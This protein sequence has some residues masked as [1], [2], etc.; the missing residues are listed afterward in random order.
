MSQS[1]SD[2]KHFLSPRSIA[3]VGASSKFDS[4]S[5]KPL[6]FLQEHGYKGYVYPINPKYPELLGYKCYKSVLEIPDEVDLV[7]V[8][9]NYKLVLPMLKQCVEKGVKFATIFSSGFAES[10]E[11]LPA[12]RVYEDLY[13]E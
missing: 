12:D 5:G 8:A 9:V 4:I 6:R 10:G 13:V 7:L 1:P 11:E 3:I 2:L